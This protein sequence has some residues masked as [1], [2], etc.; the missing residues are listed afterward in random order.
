MNPHCIFNFGFSFN[1]SEEFQPSSY[2]YIWDWGWEENLINCFTTNKF[3]MFSFNSDFIVRFL[4]NKLSP[5]I[6]KF[7]SLFIK[8]ICVIYFL[9]LSNKLIHFS[10]LKISRGIISQLNLE[11]E[12]SIFHLNY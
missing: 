9:V 1:Y 8:F 10:A 5:L 6:I 7:F 4:I 2:Q 11:F 12:F 3:L